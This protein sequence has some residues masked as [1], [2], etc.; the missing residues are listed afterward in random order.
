MTDA[1]AHRGPDGS[2]VVVF[3]G[4]R[5]AGLGHRRLAIIDPS[6]AGAQPMELGGRWWITYNGELYNFRELRRELESLGHVFRT[7]SDTEVLLR[8]F[9]VWG[10][11]ML[12]RLNGIFA[13][14]IWDNLEKKLFLARDRLGVKPLYYT[15]QGGVFAFASEVKPLLPY[16]RQVRLDHSAL[17]DYL[18]L[19][20]VPDPRTGFEEIAQL[21]AGHYARV[22]GEDLTIHPYWDLEFC[23]EE[24]P[25]SVWC[26]RVRDAVAGAV[27][28]QM[29]SDVPLGSFLSGGIDSSAVVAAMAA[30]G[31]RVTTYTIGINEDDLSYE[32]TPGDLGYARVVGRHFG[33]D[34]HETMLEPD[35]LEL[36]PKAVWHLEEP[37][38]D[39]AAIS[40]YLVCQAAGSRMPVM[41]S[42]VGGDEI[43]AG[44]PRYLAYRLSR[45]ADPFPD[46]LTRAVTWALRPVARPGPPGRLRGPRRNLWKFMRASSLPPFERYLSYLSYYTRNELN[47]ILTDGVVETSYDPLSGHRAHLAKPV[48]GGELNRLLY[49]DAKTFL[50]CLN[51]AYTD[52][53][54][55]A[56]SVE[57]R[58]P[59]LDNELVELAGRIPTRL[60]LRRLQRKYIFKKSQ[61]GILP[62]EI[63]WRPK[64]GF[65]AP[66]RSWLASDLA[67]LMADLL[68]ERVL[69]ERGLIQPAVVPRI[70]HEN[71]TGQADHS[72]RLY[73]FLTLE[74][75]CR[76]FID[77][78]WQFSDPPSLEQTPVR[79]VYD[80][81]RG[82]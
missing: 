60:K 15:T 30:T 31:E 38:A 39:P 67:P 43:F 47:D 77:R 22:D 79:V 56:S 37:L 33:T 10:P 32:V 5:P 21:S 45:F 55:M 4:Q 42:G 66:L 34:Y 36:L 59:F 82:G 44:Y 72:L 48:E 6:P 73:A 41:L 25:E 28:R 58:V 16:L 8:M 62:R 18:T 50:P 70:Q 80:S 29:V 68:S 17:A 52:K 71:S 23:P 53:M 7:A 81:A 75:W 49:L 14:A 40:T 65:G 61:E 76:T 2:G 69:R 1:M 57:V 26:D 13:F 63:V 19:L 78:S 64:A 11:A 46:A 27:R 20:W 9:A 35:V 54:S 12:D 24:L 74:L 3:P 51:L